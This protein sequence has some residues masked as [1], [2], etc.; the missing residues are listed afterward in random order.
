MRNRLRKLTR[1]N[2]VA[3]TGLP[4]KELLEKKPI[5]DSR[6]NTFKRTRRHGVD[7]LVTGNPQLTMGRTTS[8]EHVDNYFDAK[9]REQRGK[10]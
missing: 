8:I 5:S 6:I 9:V 7:L 2:I 10:K 4:F 3:T 1:Q